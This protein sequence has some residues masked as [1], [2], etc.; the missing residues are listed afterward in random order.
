VAK[1]ID[2]VKQYPIVAYV[3]PDNIPSLKVFEGLSFAKAGTKTVKNT[4]LVRF[5]ID[6]MP[7]KLGL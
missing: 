2:Y 5:Q 1:G 4:T 7:E 3:K 6:H